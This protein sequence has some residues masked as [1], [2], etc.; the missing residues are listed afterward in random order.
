MKIFKN[1]KAE[2]VKEKALVEIE[3][4]A[5]SI[6]KKVNWSFEVMQGRDNYKKLYE[7]KKNKNRELELKANEKSEKITTL[8]LEL[9]RTRQER[10]ALL[11]FLD[12][13]AVAF[14]DTNENLVKEIA[15]LKSDRYLVVKQRATKATTQKIGIK[16]G[17][18]TSKIIKKV[19]EN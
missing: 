9:I 4:F 2:L 3:D 11:N 1:K 19:K 10:D 12:K 7:L 13:V 18:K 17:T 15:D 16:S 6:L 14:K 5:N 8:N